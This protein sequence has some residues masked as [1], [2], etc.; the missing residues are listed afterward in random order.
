MVEPFLASV[1]GVA[2]RH[3]AS[4]GDNGL[5]LTQ[6]EASWIRSLR[7]SNRSERTIDSY[8]LALRQLVEVTGDVPASEVSTDD[9]R[10]FLV[11]V[12][13]TRAPAT[14]RQRHASL[15]QFFKWAF[16]EG[17]IDQDPMARVKAPKIVE[18][19]VEVL[20]P[21]EVRR[22]LDAASGTGFNESRDSAI[23]LVLYDTGIR[24][25]ELTGIRLDDINW[26]TETI[27][28]T[29]KGGRTREVGFGRAAAKA[30]DRYDR[31]RRLHSEAH[32]P[33]FWLGRKGPL[34]GSGVHQMLNRRAEVAGIGHVFAHQFRHTFSHT[35]L[36]S[37]GNEGD[38]MRLGGWSSS[39]ML[40]RYGRSAADARAR[41]AHRRL[42]P[43]DH[44]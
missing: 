5:S 42:S 38:L 28:V 16:E 13:E 26:A 10:R 4:T 25:G 44:L 41:E 22:L 19:P 29:G 21:D 35:W 8:L 24:M 17:E 43:G 27:R 31:R 30:L 18:Q 15:K 40:R 20:T 11:R 9:V 33:E 39:Q 1:F 2:R 7:A 36:E 34:S 6:L 32:R 14:A 23:I 37:G 12:I 3:T